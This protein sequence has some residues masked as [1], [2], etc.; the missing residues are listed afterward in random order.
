[1]FNY[2]YYEDTSKWNTDSW[3]SLYRYMSRMIMHCNDT[4]GSKVPNENRIEEMK[5]INLKK[6]SND[7]K[8]LFI[9]IIKTQN[10]E[11]TLLSLE[12]LT[13]LNTC[14]EP[15]NKP[16]IDDPTLRIFPW[17]K[18]YNIVKGKT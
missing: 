4:K 7:V 1:M 9:A 2:P 18:E 16:I 12:N 13:E 14:T 8:V 17:Y 11:G 15:L 5:R 6:M 10:M 3:Y